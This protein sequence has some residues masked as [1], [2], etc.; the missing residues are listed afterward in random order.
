M[1]FSSRYS[2]SIHRSY[3]DFV[4]KMRDYQSC[5]AKCAVIMNGRE[6][7]GYCVYFVTEDEVYGE[8]FAAVSDSAYQQL[9]EA[10]AAR[11]AGKKLTIRMASDVRLELDQAQSRTVPKSVLGVLDAPALMRSLEL[12]GFSVQ[13]KDSIIPKNEGV[14]DISGPPHARSAAAVS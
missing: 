3:A 10:M 6:A 8:E 7:Q 11:S 13:I 12:E 1:R 14:Y 5:V 4:L 2:G 9:F